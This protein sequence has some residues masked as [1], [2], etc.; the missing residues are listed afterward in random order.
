MKLRTKLYLSPLVAL[1]VGCLILV[2]TEGLLDSQSRQVDVLEATQDVRRAAFELTQVTTEHILINNERT[3]E[4][5]RGR[6]KSLGVLLE[7]E[8]HLDKP[9]LERN[10]REAGEFFDRLEDLRKDGEGP[11]GGTTEKREKR[12]ATQILVRLTAVNHLSRS[13]AARAAAALEEHGRTARTT[14]LVLVTVLIATLVV[15]SVGQ[16][17]V[18]GARIGDLLRA[19]QGIRPSDMAARAKGGDDELGELAHAFNKMADRLSLSQRELSQNVAVLD[20]TNRKLEKSNQEL[21][22]FAYVASH[23][24]K[25]PLRAMWNLSAWIEEELGGD[26]TERTAGYLTLLRTRVDRMQ[27][28]I[29]DLL[30]YSRAGRKEYANN[31]FL[32]PEDAAKIEADAAQYAADRHQVSDPNRK[33]PPV[34]GDGTTGGAGNVGGYNRFWV[35]T[36]TEAFAVD[37]KFRTSIIF[38]PPNGRIPEM[39][40]AGQARSAERRRLRRP[41]DG[42]ALVARHRGPWPVRRSGNAAGDRALHR[43]LHRRHADLPEPLQQLQARGPDRGPHHDPDRDGP[44]RPHRAPER[45]A[46]ESRGT[47]VARSLH[48]LVGR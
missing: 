23:D 30:E 22:Q 45:G 20:R 10:Y 48:R 17:G 11:S 46:S 35:E 28:L 19:V 42:S 14:L 31:L 37:G 40:E 18:V 32:S 8:P 3:R 29:E 34:G 4:Q 6:Y 26:V 36:G 15:T 39:T 12:Y 7:R 33:P 21:E 47:E 41:N 43:R 16:A 5:W 2:I 9:E 13:A 24:L 27:K 25:A 44:R 38:D 1:V